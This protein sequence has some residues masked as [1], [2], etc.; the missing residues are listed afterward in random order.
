MKDPGINFKTFKKAFETNDVSLIESSYK[1][2][3]GFRET[4]RR[5]KNLILKRGDVVKK[6]NT[7]YNKRK[8]EKELT[9]P[10]DFVNL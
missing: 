3:W 9:E 2:I 6:L 1:N 7:A 8:V 5:E 4:L 10:F